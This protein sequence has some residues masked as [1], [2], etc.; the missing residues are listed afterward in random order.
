MNWSSLSKTRAALVLGAAAGCA[1]AVAGLWGAPAL[2]SALAGLGCVAALAGF[3]ALSR[4]SRALADARRLCAA[5][6]KGDFETRLLLIRERGEIGDFLHEMNDMADLV[7][8]YVREATASLEAMR[9]NCYY[10]RILPDG[11]KGAMLISATTINE[12]ADAVEARVST[13]DS[14]TEEFSAQINRIVD[15]L[16]I[17][18]GGIGALAHAFAQGSGATGARAKDLGAAAGEASDSVEAVKTAADRLASSAQEVGASMRRTVDI[19]HDAVAAAQNTGQAVESLNG[20]VA[21]I[22]AIVGIINKIAVQTNLLAL[23]ATIE[24]SRAGEAGRGFA[25]VAGEVKSLAEQTTKATDEI[26]G[27]IAEVEQ[28]TQAA[29]A[30]TGE[31]G[32][33]IA[34]ID[35]VTGAALPQ[36]ESQVVG[37]GEIAD[38]L[39]TTLLRTRQVLEALSGIQATATEGLGQAQNVT[40]AAGAIGQESGRLNTTV[41]E[42]LVSLR[43]GPLD[44]RETERHELGVGARIVTARGE[45][46]TTVFDVSRSG[47]K[48]SPSEGLQAGD[49]AVLRFADGHEVNITVRWVHDNQAGVALSPGAINE[50]VLE[51]LRRMKAA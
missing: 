29:V 24:A 47:A 2:A 26:A 41:K 46:P 25:V 20:A 4:L 23:N 48:L 44:R 42:F 37:A 18:S 7:D 3:W 9:R 11:L 30:S 28:A 12:A 5:V 8:A 10:R 19:A 31:I 33:R 50:A 38:H 22:G 13:F 17:S 16:S 45:F 39:Q 27:L 34:D 35:E 51:K 43:R 36:I 14:S 21:R 32:A 40:G 6:A 49:S 15:Q 1:G